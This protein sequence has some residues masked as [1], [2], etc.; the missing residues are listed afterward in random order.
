MREQGKVLEHQ[1]DPTRFR[2]QTVAGLGYD[3]A[4]HDDP[5]ALQRLQAG[6][7]AQDG[8]LAAARGPTRQCTSAGRMDRVTSSTTRRRPKAWRSPVTASPAAGAG[9]AKAGSCKA[10][11][12]SED[13]SGSFGSDEKQVRCRGGEVNPSRRHPGARRCESMPPRRL[14]RS[15]SDSR[16][17]PPPRWRAAAEEAHRSILDTR[18]IVERGKVEVVRGPARVTQVT[19]R[20]GACGALWMHPAG[21]QKQVERAFA[22]ADAAHLLKLGAR[23][24][25]MKA[26][27]ARVSRAA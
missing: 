13:S 6:D 23:D 24:R 14:P 27:I 12:T 5:P 1:P 7:Q 19:G 11:A 18:Q 3:D 25:L 4:I 15:A 20:P 26:M 16:P 21:L 8:G 22:D 10:R 2:R 9:S 17:R